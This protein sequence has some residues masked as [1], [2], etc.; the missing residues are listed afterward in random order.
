MNDFNPVDS[1]STEEYTQLVTEFEVQNGIIDSSQTLC[2]GRCRRY[3]KHCKYECTHKKYWEKTDNNDGTWTE[4]YKCTC[5][6]HQC[7]G[8]WHFVKNGEFCCL[9]CEVPA[10]GS[11]VLMEMISQNRVTTLHGDFNITGERED[12]LLSYNKEGM[13]E[14]DAEYT[15]RSLFLD[16][17]NHTYGTNVYVGNISQ[18]P[19]IHTYAGEKLIFYM[20][21][22]ND[23]YINKNKFFV[24]NVT[25]YHIVVAEIITEDYRSGVACGRYQYNFIAY[26]DM[27]DLIENNKIKAIF[28]SFL[29]RFGK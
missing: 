6:D 7:P 24:A 11:A 13:G 28:P 10:F 23:K 14:H 27:K 15:M 26:D 22:S 12:Y 5:A 16:T 2:D 19:S 9:E 3:S 1:C 18:V 8:T 29:F 20:Y 4:W 21:D 17:I 25:K